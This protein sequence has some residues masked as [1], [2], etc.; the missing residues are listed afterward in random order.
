MVARLRGDPLAGVTALSAF[1]GHDS[2]TEAQQDGALL[3]WLGI[4]DIHRLLQGLASKSISEDLD[5]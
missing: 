3:V 2:P 4:R 1:M 5:P